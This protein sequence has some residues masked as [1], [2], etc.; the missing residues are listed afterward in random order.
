MNDGR[1]MGD[2]GNDGRE[3]GDDD[4]DD[5]NEWKNEDERKDKYIKPLIK[6]MQIKNCF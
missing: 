4:D 2:V 5:D 3:M 1:E 6:G